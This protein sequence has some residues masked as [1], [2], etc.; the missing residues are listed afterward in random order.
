MGNKVINTTSVKLGI[1]ETSTDEQLE[2]M[3]GDV[4]EMEDGRKFR[5]CHN[6]A[7][8]LAPGYLVQSKIEA[9]N[10]TGLS[11]IHI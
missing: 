7:G 2:G 5:L 4:K 11:L 1:Y 3:L 9:G 8:V 6:G 10:V